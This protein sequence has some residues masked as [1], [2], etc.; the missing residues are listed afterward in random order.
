MNDLERI[1]NHVR[2][3]NLH[4]VAVPAH[5]E[6]WIIGLPGTPQ[7]TH[8]GNRWRATTKQAQQLIKEALR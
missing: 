5:K 2:R 3:Y 1:R 8:A 7:L 6:W 4:L